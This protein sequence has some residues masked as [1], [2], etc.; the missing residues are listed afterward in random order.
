MRKKEKATSETFI[1]K[2]DNT[3][4]FSEKAGNGIV[5][6]QMSVDKHGK[7]ARYS[8]AYINFRLCHVDNGRVIGYDNSHGYHHRHY[9]GEEEPIDFISFEAIA[10]QFE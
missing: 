10:E 9:F 7:L 8:L 1:K 6:M 5:K 4:K 3:F 2:I